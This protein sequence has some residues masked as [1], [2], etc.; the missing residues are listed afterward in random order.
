MESNTSDSIQFWVPQKL[1]KELLF[2][3]GI[4]T[5]LVFKE[6]YWWLVYDTLQ[7]VPRLFQLWACKQV[8]NISGTNLIQS[9]YKIH[10]YPTCTSCDQ[11]VETCAHVLSYNEA[12]RV[13]SLYQYINI[14][15][16]WIKKVCTHT[17][18]CKYILQYDKGRGGISMADVL[19]N[20]GS[21]YSKLA[22]SQDLIGW[23]RF[24]EGMI[25]KEI[26]VIK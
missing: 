9:R 7:K 13:D 16:K 24:M 26:L 1:A 12:G 5:P 3:L 6:V 14:L 10:H 20:T 22:V 23:R 19:H 8:I 25:S 21:R 15:D 2:K 18:L 4:L 17:Q 11:C